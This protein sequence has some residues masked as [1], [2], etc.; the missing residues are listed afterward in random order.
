MNEIVYPQSINISL[1]PTKIE[2]KTFTTTLKIVKFVDRLLIF[3]TNIGRVGHIVELS[4]PLLYQTP[5]ICFSG[6]MENYETRTLLG[7]DIVCVI[8]QYF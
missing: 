7:P 4:F 3:I 2:N 8:K 1:S 5:G 6:R